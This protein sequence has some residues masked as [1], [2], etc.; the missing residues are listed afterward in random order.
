MTASEALAGIASLMGGGGLVAIAVAWLGYKAEALKGRRPMASDPSM[1]AIG[2]GFLVD[3]KSANQVA[4][5]AMALTEALSEAAEA[6]GELR[7]M[8]RQ[9]D[10]VARHAEE[11]AHQLTEIRRNGER[12]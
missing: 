12:D 11:I 4:A 2:A 9:M 1:A 7:E 6:L 3:G 5:A 10:R 8:G